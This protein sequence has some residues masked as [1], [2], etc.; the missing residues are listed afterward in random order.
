MFDDT[1][2]EIEKKLAKVRQQEEETQKHEEL[3][4][5]LLTGKVK[6]EPSFADQ[7]L[8]WL[9]PYPQGMSDRELQEKIAERDCQQNWT[10]Q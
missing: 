3:R 7:A 9:N 8:S 10:P 4:T 2:E 6:K 1:E 5:G